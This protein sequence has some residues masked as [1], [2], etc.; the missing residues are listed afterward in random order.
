ML[1]THMCRDEL[2]PYKPITCVSIS[3]SF[4]LQWRHNEG[5]GVSNHQSNDFFY[6]TVYSGADQRKYQSPASLAFVRRIHRYPV[7]SP[8]IGPVTR[9]MFPFDDVTMWNS[10][11]GRTMSH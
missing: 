11:Q 7:N 6:S 4:S 2:G 8:H 1:L 5:E 9:Q 10:A 3:Q